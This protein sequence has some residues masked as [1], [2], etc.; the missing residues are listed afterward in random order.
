V[1]LFCLTKTCTE[2][3]F[4]MPKIQ[5]IHA[6]TFAAAGREDGADISKLIAPPYDVLDETSKASLLAQDGHNI[7][8]V[9]LPHLPAKTVGP[10]STYAATGERY[11]QWQQQG[12]LGQ[13][14]KPAIYVYQQTYTVNERQFQRRGLIANVHVQPFGKATDGQ[15]GI[16]PHE[17]TFS[18][19]KEDRLKLMR[20]T[21]TQLSPIF[22]LYSDAENQVGPLLQQGIAGRAASF[23]GWTHNDVV[24]HEVWALDSGPAYDALLAKLSTADV[25]IAD[26]HHRYNT[27]LNYRNELAAKGDLPA[28]HPAN[29]CMFVLIAMQDPGMIVLPTHRVFGGMTNFTFDAFAK[30]TA[31]K[32]NIQRVDG[33]SLDALEK[34]LPQHGPHAMGIVTKD[35]TAIVTTVGTD[36][37]KASHAQQSE[38]WRQLDVAVLQHVIV[39][40][41]CQPAFCGNGEVTWKFPHSLD[42]VKKQ[43]AGEG[44]LAAI[45]QPT[46][47]ASVRLVSEAGELMPQKSTFFYPKLATG[48]VINPLA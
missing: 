17:Q 21:K 8:A 33:R 32:L 48:L 18:G 47:L 4:D 43:L 45:L 39:E 44:Q 29:W 10:D 26:G 2:L 7:V 31:G 27:A 37:L 13:R 15:G 14:G 9:D 12:V 6:V 20:A 41:I 24:L 28:D 3:R 5:P 42:E 22:G 36:P 34:L 23:K 19:P 40:G 25:F 46:P 16:H 38:A 30:A 11:R 1:Y 35:A